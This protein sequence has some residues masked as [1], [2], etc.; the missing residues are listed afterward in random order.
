MSAERAKSL[1]YDVVHLS[2]VHRSSD[3]RIYR[4]ECTALHEAGMSVAFISRGPAPH[5]DVPWIELPAV[6]GRLDRM[7]RGP[8]RAWQ[9]LRRLSPAVVHIHDPEL[10]PLGLLWR[11]K[12]GGR[13]IYDAHE[14]LPKQVAGKLYLPRW[15]RGLVAWFAR[16]LEGAAER[17]FDAIVVATPSIA[18]NFP[19]AR[20]LELVQNFPWLR[21]FPQP[22]PVSEVDPMSACY[23]GGLSRARGSDVMAAAVQANRLT[24]TVAG[25]CDDEAREDLDALGTR[26]TD[27]GLVDAGQVPAIIRGSAVGLVLFKP[28]PNNVESQ[29]TKLFE[30]M[31]AGRAFVASDFPHWR[32]LVAPANC[33]HFVN[34]ESPEEAIHALRKLCGDPDRLAEMGRQGRA[35]FEERFTFDPQSEA[36]V[37]LTRDLVSPK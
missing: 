4:K 22:T 37:S 30:Y 29:P 1:H 24:L 20:R 5:G 32:A 19:S 14:D 12:T 13:V 10:I 28:L 34:P 27:L 2:T 25:Q 6:V 15:S 16:A 3:N 8:L 11:W 36:L 9:T 7:T 26:L 17:G 18:R 21:D 35:V 31:A 23:V 33:G